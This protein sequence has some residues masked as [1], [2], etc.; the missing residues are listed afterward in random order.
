[1]MR[2]LRLSLFVIEFKPKGMPQHGARFDKISQ[3]YPRTCVDSTVLFSFVCFAFSPIYRVEDKGGNRRRRNLFNYAMTV[4]LSFC[5]YKLQ[6]REQLRQRYKSTGLRNGI[7]EVSATI[8][9]HLVAE[10]PS[11][12]SHPRLPNQETQQPD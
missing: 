2:D 8:S 4:S 9:L 1:M 12:S 10:A 7:P 11:L 6:I 3:H 5:V